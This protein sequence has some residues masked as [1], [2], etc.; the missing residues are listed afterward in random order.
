MQ[1]RGFDAELCEGV[2]E[3]G[4]G[5][6]ELRELIGQRLRQPGHVLVALS[7]VFEQLEARLQ[8][9]VHR[10]RPTAELLCKSLPG[11]LRGDQIDSY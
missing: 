1:S 5:N 2:P 4:L 8:V 3:V 10:T 7:V 11:T 9:Q 6:C